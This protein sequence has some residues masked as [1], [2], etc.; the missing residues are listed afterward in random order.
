MSKRW[1]LFPIVLTFFSAAGSACNSSDDGSA[2]G[3]DAAGAGESSGG[4]DSMGAATGGA[5]PNAEAGSPGDAGSTAETALTL[6]LLVQAHLDTGS[7][8]AAQTCVDRLAGLAATQPGHYVH[9]L[10]ATA[11]GHLAAAA[12][13]S[14]AA[15]QHY[16]D[17]LRVLTRLDLPFEAGQV[18][19]ALARACAELQPQA[20]L[21]EARAALATFDRLEASAHADAAAAFLRSLGAPGRRVPRTATTLTRREQEVLALVGYGLT[22]PEIAQRLFISRKTA[23]HHVSNL[24]TKLGL[25]NRAEAVAYAARPRTPQP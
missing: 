9:G 7:P 12:G 1:L 18:R 22:N 8:D 24:L 2:N 21:A 16:H 15:M 23:A 19:L 17:A 25:R 13:D 4:A 11:C 14:Q 10:S 5:G 6:A 3:G 20:A